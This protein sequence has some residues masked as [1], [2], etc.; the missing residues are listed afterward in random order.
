MALQPRLHLDIGWGDIA[1]IFMPLTQSRADL[2]ARIEAAWP[3]NAVP[4]LSVRTALDAMLASLALPK[5]SA[6][7]MSAVTIQNMADVVRAHGLEPVPI[8]PDVATLAPSP[9][10]IDHTLQT[11]GAKVYVHAHLYGSRNDL[12]EIAAICHARGVVLIED[13]AQG[14][15]GAPPASPPVADIS[16]YSFGPI[17]AQTCLGGAVAVCRTAE[18]AAAIRA[19]LQAHAPMPEGWLRS[20]ALKYSALKLLS[21]PTLYGWAVAILRARGIDPDKAIGGAARG[22]SGADLTASLRRAPSR[23]L[24]RLL[25]RRTARAAGGEWRAFAGRVLDTELGDAFQRPGSAAGTQAFWLYPVL[26]SDPVAAMASM[27]AAGFDATRGA[28]SLRAI[29]EGTNVLAPN[30]TRLIDQVLYLPIAPAMSERT[31]KRMARAL[32]EGVQPLQMDKK[33]VAA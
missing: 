11:T 7:A 15:A 3:A 33:K 32:R 19:R 27:R 6:V 17:K 31:L 5:G 29:T 10:Q 13:C 23:T 2:I 20:R 25:A 9:A 21:S 30:A 1:S 18:T 22:F 12:S 8:D 14:Y 4:A 16:L 24:L 28:T 26:V